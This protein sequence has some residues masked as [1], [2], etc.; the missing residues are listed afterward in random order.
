MLAVRMINYKM[1]AE[2]IE[3]VLGLEKMSNCSWQLKLLEID[4]MDIV[5]SSSSSVKSLALAFAGGNLRANEW[6]SAWP[7]KVFFFMG[8]KRFLADSYKHWYWKNKGGLFVQSTWVFK[9]YHIGQHQPTSSLCDAKP[10][11][12]QRWTT[13]TRLHGTDTSVIASDR[14]FGINFDYGYTGKRV[15]YVYNNK[16]DSTW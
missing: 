11:Y 7:G 1:W 13:S 6:A 9:G 5:F 10:I 12:S 15:Q 4:L 8:Q 14:W 16:R 3:F 2:R